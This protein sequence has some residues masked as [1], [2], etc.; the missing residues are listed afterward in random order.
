MLARRGLPVTILARGLSDPMHGQMRLAHATVNLL[1]GAPAIGELM[2]RAPQADVETLT[3]D[4]T[5]TAATL[6][7]A[8]AGLARRPPRISRNAVRLATRRFGYSSQRARTELG[9]RPDD[10]ERRLADTLAYWRREADANRH[11]RLAALEA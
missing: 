8:R 3:D 4:A 7:E 6:E 10:F 5:M 1:G 9:W 11:Y 2:F